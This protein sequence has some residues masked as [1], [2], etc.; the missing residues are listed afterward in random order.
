MDVCP[1]TWW[2]KLKQQRPRYPLLTSLI[3]SVKILDH[4][5]LSCYLIESLCYMP[6]SFQWV[7]GHEYVV[8]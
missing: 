2:S 4:S 6:P 5:T 3:Q 1:Y 7:S 8:S